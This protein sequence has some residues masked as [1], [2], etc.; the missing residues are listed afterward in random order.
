[1]EDLGSLSATGEE[2]TPEYV[3]RLVPLEIEKFR[4]VLASEKVTAL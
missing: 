2:L 4:K 1:M 3:S